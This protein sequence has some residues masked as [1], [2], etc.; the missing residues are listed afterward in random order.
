MKDQGSFTNLDEITGHTFNIRI[1]SS[2]AEILES[3]LCFLRT[4]GQNC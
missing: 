2:C 3:Q 4:A 1:I